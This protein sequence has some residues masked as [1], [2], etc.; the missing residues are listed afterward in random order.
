MGTLT[1]RNV[2]ETT[3]ALLRQRAAA[4]GRSVEAEVRTILTE[5]VSA[6][7]RNLLLELHARVGAQAIDLEIPPRTDLPREVDLP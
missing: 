1:I 5:A 6:P 7:T 3:H 2:D 4:Q